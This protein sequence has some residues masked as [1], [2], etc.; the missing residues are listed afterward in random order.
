MNQLGMM[1]DISHVSG[2]TFWDVMAE[3]QRRADPG[4]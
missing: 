1:V 3:N 4:D 2:E